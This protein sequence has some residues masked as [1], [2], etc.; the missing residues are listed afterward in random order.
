[1]VALRGQGEGR[2]IAIEPHKL[3]NVFPKLY[4]Q[5]A[6]TAAQLQSRARAG[7][8]VH[9]K[10]SVPGRARVESK[11]EF[12]RGWLGLCACHR[13]GHIAKSATFRARIRGAPPGRHRRSPRRVRLRGSRGGGPAPALPRSS[14]ITENH[15]YF[16][17]RG[18][19][20]STAK[21]KPLPRDAVAPAAPRRSAALGWP[22][23]SRRKSTGACPY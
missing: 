23:C 22:G 11:I 8:G 18:P 9:V 17:A 2:R 20:V 19:R 10:R 5:A 3:L 4:A 15:W 12:R 1:L 13:P 16:H 6:V 7:D 14:P 21:A